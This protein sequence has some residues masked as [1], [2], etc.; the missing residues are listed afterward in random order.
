MGPISSASQISQSGGKRRVWY[1]LV[2]KDGI[3]YEETPA[4]SVMVSSADIIDDLTKAV[5]RDSPNDLAHCDAKR[6]SVYQNKADLL[7]N[8][9]P[10]HPMLN[11]GNLGEDGHRPLLVKVPSIQSVS[12]SYEK[13]LGIFFKN[14]S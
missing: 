7:K 13:R 8:E 9:N 2:K 3:P 4:A 1:Q 10:L 14:D 11:I 5:K 12:Q 6:L